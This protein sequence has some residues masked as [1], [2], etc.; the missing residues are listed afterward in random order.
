MTG[1]FDTAARAA[2]A[3][4]VEAA[5]DGLRLDGDAARHGLSAVQA[6]GLFAD[7]SARVAPGDQA[8]LTALG[9]AR[10]LDARLRLIGEDGRVRYARLMGQAG[11]DGVW[12]VVI[13]LPRDQDGFAFERGM[14][15]PVA[16]AAW[17]GAAR[18]RGGEKGVS[19]WY[20]LSL[21][22]PV[23]PLRM[24]LVPLLVIA[25]AAGLQFAALRRWRARAAVSPAG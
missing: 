10:R 15:V 18:E 20:F 24:Y 3:V 25:A 7:F 6:S 2:G 17:D 13:T 19:T 8:V 16:F 1:L 5:G 23:N 14:T 22:Q 21:E 11:E 9:E 12:R 4:A